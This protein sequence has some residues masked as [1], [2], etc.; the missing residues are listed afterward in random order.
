[1]EMSQKRKCDFWTPFF[2]FFSSNKKI[3]TICFV[4]F[5]STSKR[6]EHIRFTKTFRNNP[7][8]L[9]HA[10]HRTNMSVTTNWT[11]RVCNNF[12]P[13]VSLNPAKV[14]RLWDPE[15]YTSYYYGYDRSSNVE[16][17]TTCPEEIQGCLD[18]YGLGDDNAVTLERFVVTPEYAIYR[19]VDA[20]QCDFLFKTNDGETFEF[21][22]QEPE[23]SC[24]TPYIHS[25]V[26]EWDE[27]DSSIRYYLPVERSMCVKETM[28]DGKSS[29][30]IDQSQPIE[31]DL[32]DLEEWDVPVAC[33]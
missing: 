5:I 26:N 21:L 27:N 7:K 9:S 2:K 4:T 8:L 25:I 22:L 10:H 18:A 14:V 28:A 29:W 13:T 24:Y 16:N 33:I 15:N 6:Y 19:D 31:D 1:M 11:E 17:A 32:L 12:P 20:Y 3:E 23:Y 30:V